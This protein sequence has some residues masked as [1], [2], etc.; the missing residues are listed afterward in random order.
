[1]KKI[2]LIVM[3]L[4]VSMISLQA[5]ENLI[6]N[7]DFEN[8]DFAI[9]K[10]ESVDTCVVL[11][12]GWDSIA[13][14][15]AGDFNNVGLNMYNVRGVMGYYNPVENGNYHYF[16]LQRY[17]W[18]GWADGG[19]Q[20]TVDVAPSTTYTLSFLYRLSSHAENNTLVP[21]WYSIQEDSNDPVQKA[22]YN[23]MDDNWYP[24]TKTFTTSATAK[25]VKVMLGVTGGKI[26]SWGGNINLYADFDNVS[27]VSGTVS[28]IKDLAAAGNQIKAY[29]HGSEL[30]LSGLDVDEVVSIYNVIGKL[31]T[32]FNPSSESATVTLPNK[33]VYIVK[34]GLQRTLKVIIE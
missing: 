25:Q 8:N 14:L 15:R 27:L 16:R 10:Y 17:E 13:P 21:A 26:Y 3:L 22:L 18:E 31:V 12:A 6:V 4:F 9:F 1:M 32:S 7:G 11:L 20:Q 24:K 2:T 34:N 29:V 23:N 33:G 28:S 5:Q 30:N 19:I